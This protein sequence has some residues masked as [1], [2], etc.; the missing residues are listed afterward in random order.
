MPCLPNHVY[1][2]TSKGIMINE[3]GLP[4]LAQTRRND[5][6]TKADPLDTQMT[7]ARTKLLGSSARC[8]EKNSPFTP[9]GGSNSAI[10][11]FLNCT[12]TSSL[13]ERAFHRLGS[14]SRVRK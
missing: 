5:S 11:A 2:I 1:R 14:S 7:Y 8:Y 12:S 4:H 9:S 10:F 3:L 13:F 6:N